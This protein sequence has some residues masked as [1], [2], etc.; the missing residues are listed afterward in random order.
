MRLTELQ[1]KTAYTLDGKRLGRVHEIHCDNEIVVALKLG[2]GSFIE[3]MTSK[4]E[5]RRV[6]W[7]SVCRVERNRILVVP[8]PPEREGR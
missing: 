1:N 8:D 3:R 6:D 4:T 7:D 2:P 5:G